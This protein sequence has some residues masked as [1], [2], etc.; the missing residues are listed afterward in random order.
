L[1]R[2]SSALRLPGDNRFFCMK[3]LDQRAMIELLSLC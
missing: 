3:L 2:A 1:G